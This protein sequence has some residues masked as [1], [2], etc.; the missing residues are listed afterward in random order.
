M[1]AHFAIIPTKNIDKKRGEN[2]L[3]LCTLFFD[4]L[5]NFHRADLCADAAGDALGGRTFSG[6]DHNLHGADL[7]TLTAGG[8]EL[9][10]DHVHTGLGV[11]SDR[12]G[13]TNLLTL[14][15]LDTGHRLCAGTLGNDL[16]AR[17]IGIKSLIEGLGASS[18]TFQACHTLYAL[19]RHQ[20]LH[21][22]KSPFHKFLHYY[23]GCHGK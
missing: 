2:P 19:F 11:L 17:Q 5:Q 1:R 21:E 14:A 8:A 10:V 9:L 22:I 3:A 18:D 12:A 20:F 13:L 15:A 7:H 6:S 16:N 4:D 23:T